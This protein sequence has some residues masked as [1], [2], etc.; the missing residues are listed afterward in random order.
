[1]N[2][3]KTIDIFHNILAAVSW[4]LKTVISTFSKTKLCC[5]L[6]SLLEAQRL[7]YNH[8]PYAVTDKRAP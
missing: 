3:T 1:M 4:Q 5:L 8:R 2:I 6:L 7:E